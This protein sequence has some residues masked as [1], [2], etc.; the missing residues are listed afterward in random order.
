VLNFNNNTLT[1]NEYNNSFTISSQQGTSFTI[2]NITLYSGAVPQAEAPVDPNMP[3]PVMST[4][5]LT[6]NQ[7]YFNTTLQSPLTESINYSW[8]YLLY[9]Y[10][11]TADAYSI[12]VS[13]G[14][15]PTMANYTV[16]AGESWVQNGPIQVP[17]C[18]WGDSIDVVLFFEYSF[19]GNPYSFRQSDYYGNLVPV[20]GVGGN[21]VPVD[22]L[23]LLAALLA[24][25]LPYAGVASAAIIAVA[26]ATAVYFKR[27]KRRQEKQ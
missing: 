19:N 18:N 17:N 3:L 5:G 26:V 13:N 4:V 25:Y 2:G 27:I 10:N 16:P 14:T 24:P 22:T 23:A 7:L 21:V 15:T 9:K 8:S 12:A 11:A 6:G 1:L 20:N